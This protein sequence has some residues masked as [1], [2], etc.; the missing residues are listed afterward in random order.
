MIVNQKLQIY[1]FV[2]QFEYW[3]KFLRFNKFN[4][5][6]KKFK[7]LCSK[8]S[9]DSL[10]ISALKNGKIEWV[11]NMEIII[12]LPLFVLSILLVKKINILYFQS[13]FNIKF[14][15]GNFPSIGII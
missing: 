14:L 8:N 11:L 7:P 1:F 3:N 10:L 4:V 12:F 2:Q 13:H 9:I 6:Q 5:F 15:S